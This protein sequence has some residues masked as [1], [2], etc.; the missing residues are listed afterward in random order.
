MNNWFF[1]AL[2]SPAIF[3]VNIFI[4]KYVLVSKV[5]DYRGVVVYSAITGLTAGTLFWI[6]FK[7]PIL[8]LFD[9]FIIL[10]TGILTIWGYYFYFKA[11]SS[12]QTSYIIGLLQMIPVVTL[13]FSFVFLKETISSL[14][15]LGFFLV[16]FSATALSYKKQK[17]K[18]KLDPSFYYIL[19]ADVFFAA[20]NVLIKFAT[21]TNSF[22]Q[23]ITY[24]SWGIAIGGIILF[25]AVQPVRSAFLQT[26]KTAGKKVLGIMFLN[27]TILIV[28]KAVTFL[29][30][31]LGSVS[32]VTVLGGTQVFY[33]IILGIFLTIIAPHIFKENIKKKELTKK[34]IF[35]GILFVGIWLIH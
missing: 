20:G 7:M 25:L 33:G 11:L 3:T 31:S 27:E 18:F 34:I 24:E 35:M 30:I 14:Q 2:L 6:M 32:L 16:L 1:L 15:L 29:A 26:T 5:K 19:L 22:T 8:P 10:T 23:I 12:S 17:K 13:I 21:N 28:A 9:A 4:D